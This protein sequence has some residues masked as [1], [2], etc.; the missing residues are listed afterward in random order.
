MVLCAGGKPVFADIE[1]NT[2]NIAADEVER[3]IDQSTGAVIATHLHGL[4]CDIE[5]IADICAERRV[6]LIEDAAQCFGGQVGGK[7][8]GTF[9]DVGV[10]SF[11]RGKHVSALYGGMLTIRD[12][13]VYKQIR[14]TALLYPP[15]SFT[16]LFKQSLTCLLADVV[17]A[18]W[19]FRNMT[20]RLFRQD[21]LGGMNV[22]RRYLMSGQAPQAYDQLPEE[23]ASQMTALQAQLVL[24]QLCTVERYTRARLARAR[25]YHEGLS[26]IA[27][28]RLAP[29]RDDG[30]QIYP[31]FPLQVE[32]REQL[33]GH[34]MRQGRDVRAC[35]YVNAADAECYAAYARN[36]PNARIAAKCC[37][38][39]PTYPRY[40]LSEAKKNIDVIRAFFGKAHLS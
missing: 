33:V 19:V 24:D 38:V 20:F 39:L 35:Q 18:P 23:Y 6:P 7:S 22:F 25:L 32:V 16:R 26:D 37:F 5:R 21:Y 9:G 13:G 36:C 15:E 29:F 3:L 28:I 40:S 27:D 12:A 30:S 8:V 34:M 17:T 11:N 2:C 10:Y 31:S 1:A 14:D 4:S